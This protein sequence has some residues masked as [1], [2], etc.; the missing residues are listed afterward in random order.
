MLLLKIIEYIYKYNLFVI[1][2]N[3]I[4]LRIYVYL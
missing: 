3:I 4:E 1:K 2:E